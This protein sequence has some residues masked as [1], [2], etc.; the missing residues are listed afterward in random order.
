MQLN[1]QSNHPIELRRTNLKW[2]GRSGACALIPAPVKKGPFCQRFSIPT[3]R[4]AMP[5]APAPLE[6]QA[7]A[8]LCP[9]PMLWVELF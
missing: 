4:R 2:T 9:V 7:P 6:T 1:Q 8:S 5:K 3:N